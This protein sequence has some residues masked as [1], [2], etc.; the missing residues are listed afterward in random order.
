MLLKILSNNITNYFLVFGIS[1]FDNN[2]NMS[3]FGI[4]NLIDKLF[5]TFSLFLITYAWINFYIR[6]LLSTFILS[7]IFSLAL[8]YVIFLLISKKE[9][10]KKLSAKQKEDI[11]KYFL[12][13]RLLT[14]TEK[15]N[16]L[17]QILSLDFETKLTRSKLVYTKE[18]LSHT[19]IIATHIPIISQDDL[20]NLLE[21]S[22]I[23]TECVDIICN[24]YLNTV[25]KDFVANLKINFVTKE[26]LFVDY[27]DKYK[28]YPSLLKIN[29]KDL[30]LNFKTILKNFIQP[31]KSKQFFWCGFVLIFSSII[32]PFKTYYL[33]F[34]SLFLLASIACKVMPKFKK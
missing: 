25:N 22:E 23:K 18:N 10:K 24:D 33:I 7:V 20:L 14:K 8:T 21:Q 16:L 12:A 13:F 28:I 31:K 34:G 3:K 15:L 19:I 11:N 1:K 29:S 4:V 32:L 2:F 9:T 27:F 6:D 17:N 30:K 5:I 26:S